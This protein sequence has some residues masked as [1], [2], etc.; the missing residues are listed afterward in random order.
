MNPLSA[1]L[2]TGSLAVCPARWTSLW[3]GA[4]AAML[5]I[6]GVNS[7]SAAPHSKTNDLTDLSL[8]ALME[9]DV[10]KV[11]SASKFEQK[12]TEAPAIVTVINS[13][14]I[15][16]QGYRTLADVLQSAPGFNV[17][18]DRNYS[19][20]GVQGLSLG[21]FNSR[22]LLLVDGHRQNNNLTGGAYV[23]NSF[24]L[25]L[26]LIDHVEIIQGPN[27]VLY[28]NNA[29]FGVVNVVT[30]KADQIDGA[31]VSGEYGKFESY[32]ARA[33]FG[34][35][36]T[37]GLELILSGSMQG[38]DGAEQLY[39]P[40]F[41][42][43]ISNQGL[44][45][46]LD[47]ES[48][49]SAFSSARYGCLSLEAAFNH[50]EKDNPTAQYFT[51][52]NVPGLTTK[53]DRG[54][55]NL[56]L[57]KEI[58]GV[59]DVLAQVYYDYAAHS[60]G[61]PFGPPPAGPFYSEEE[62][63]QWG[64]VEL[65]LSKHLWEKHLITV[66]AEYR[67]D[68][69]QTDLVYEP[70]THTKFTDTQSDRESYGIYAEGDFELLKELHLNSGVRYDQYGNY[71]PAVDPRVALIY[72]P[73]E[74]ST[75]K[76][77]YGTAF[78]APNFLEL[79]DPR[80]KNINPEDIT[81]YDLVLEQEICRN[82]RASASGFYNRMNDLIVFTDG[83]YQNIDVES[84]GIE[85]ALQGAWQNGISGRASYTLQD[86]RNLSTSLT[87]P[88]SPH[89]LVRLN[90]TA[91]LIKDKVF[92]SLEFQFT[93]Q[94]STLFTTATGQTLPGQNVG[95]YNIVNFN[96]F[97][98]NLIKGL[99]IS[100]SIYNLFDER[101]S[102]PASTQHLQAQLPQDGRSFRFKLTYHF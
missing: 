11:S 46:N 48:S 100:A 102:D 16:N 94:R 8:E 93:D 56:K 89:N 90:L 43:P 78:R 49:W 60:I 59:F 12:A 34:K 35:N 74:H 14:Q 55:V 40:D 7:N 37:N 79:S 6:F 50:R 15:K 36:F 38:N 62:V 65:Q 28:G 51:S 80:F 63:G 31:E 30:K 85:F 86:A 18:S 95:A 47:G 52:F 99:E 84:E 82:L 2:P 25:D 76:A 64:G 81:S 101:Y 45:R 75:I 58:P 39:F 91:P 22:I 77:I 20:V 29:F 5:L 83:K 9:I 87:L 73:F 98:K 1:M 68:F 24:I 71:S 21:D 69:S 17:S 3:R 13:E 70:A 23:D 19:F 92:A 27:A 54:F 67:N 10:P 44:A 88:D 97:S 96:V 66:G 4:L 53:D 61:Y 26:D 32:R 41:D 33:T 72:N 57:S 42:S